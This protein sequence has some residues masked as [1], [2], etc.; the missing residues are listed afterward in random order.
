MEFWIGLSVGMHLGKIIA[1]YLQKCVDASGILSPEAREDIAEIEKVEE[2]I[3]SI[4]DRMV[5]DE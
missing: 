2:K 3:S 5:D 1:D 4:V